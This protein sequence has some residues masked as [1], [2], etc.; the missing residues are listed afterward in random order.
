MKFDVAIIGGGLSALVAGISL[1]KEGRRTLI[2]SAGQSA[3]HFFSGSFDLI[4]TDGSQ[5]EAISQLP[6]E[7]PYSKVGAQ[8]VARLAAGVPAFFAEFGYTLEGEEDR[9]HARKTT[10]G[11]DKPCWLTVKTRKGVY[12][13]QYPMSPLGIGLQVALRKQFEKLGGTFLAGDTVTGGDFGKD[14]LECIYTANHGYGRF[15]ADNF[16]LASG[17]FFSGG[18]EASQEK[19]FEPVF[20]LDVDYSG[21]RSDW[22]MNN[23]FEAQPYMKFG[24]HT[25]SDFK[26]SLGGNTVPNLYAVGSALSGCNA[27][28]EGCGGGVAIITALAVAE[29]ILGK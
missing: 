5:L 4:A 27:I 13:E 29:K 25:D 19:V 10:F 3:L 17:S 16:I 18:L 11:G 14:G 15:E 28:K 21:T 7:H 20:G 2:V 26:V 24:V 8:D 23:T 12:P 1:Q 6:A 22:F 9:N